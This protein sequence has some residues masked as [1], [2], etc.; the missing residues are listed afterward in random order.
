MRCFSGA[1]ISA[2]IAVPL[3]GLTFSIARSFAAKPILAKSYI[4]ANIGAAVRTL[5]VGSCSLA[6]FIFGLSAL[7]L[8]ALGIK[9]AL[10]PTENS[11]QSPSE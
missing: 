5:V 1:L 3:Y 9:T 4:A 11:P 2:A 7:G 6:T 10:Q 8:I